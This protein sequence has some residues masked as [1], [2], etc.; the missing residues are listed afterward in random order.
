MTDTTN[1]AQ[2]RTYHL[3]A[4]PPSWQIQHSEH[5]DHVSSTWKKF[6]T[7]KDVCFCFCFPFVES[8]L[9]VWEVSSESFKQGLKLFLSCGSTTCRQGLLLWLKQRRKRWRWLP[10]HLLT[11]CCLYL[12]PWSQTLRGAE[13]W[14]W[15]HGLAWIFV[16]ASPI[17]SESL[18]WVPGLYVFKFPRGLYC[19]VSR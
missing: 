16:P 13:K 14:G 7:F 18:G 12:V 9:C 2:W 4:K 10:A 8:L 19:K 1:M 5:W 15:R 11:V 6:S 3:P 17:E